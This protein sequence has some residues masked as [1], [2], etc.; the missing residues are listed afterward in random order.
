MVRRV[1]APDRAEHRHSDSRKAV[2]HQR[3]VALA[4]DLVEDHAGDRRRRRDSAQSRARRRR[5]IALGR[6]H[7]AP[8]P[9]ASR[10]PRR[11]R[12]SSRCPRRRAWATPSNR[13]ITPSA[14]ARSASSAA[15]QQ[16][17][18]PVAR[19]RP[20]I[21]VERCPAGGDGMECRIDII[22]S[23]FIGL[24][25]PAAAAQR[26]EQRQRQRRLAAAAR[27]RGDDQSRWCYSR[28]RPVSAEGRNR[29][30]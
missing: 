23:A 6:R 30:S 29:R 22:R 15:S 28:P 26:G 7:R 1:V 2:A 3:G 10:S 9:P 17:V 19:L 4:R 27:G 24:H 13:P 20:G 25:D 21:Q 11:Y 8:A 5:R 12:R 14:S 16:R 18:E